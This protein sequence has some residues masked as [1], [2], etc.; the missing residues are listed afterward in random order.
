MNVT[1]HSDDGDVP[2]DIKA[3][4]EGVIDRSRIL[5]LCLGISLNGRRYFLSA[6][7]SLADSRESIPID[8]RFKL[9]C[10]SKVLGAAVVLELCDEGILDLR[11]P[12][13]QYLPELAGHVKGDKI[14]VAHLVS[15]T[16]GY[17][18]INSTAQGTYSSTREA[19]Y[20]QVRKAD[21]LFEPGQVFSYQNSAAA[22]LGEIVV[23]R[24]GVSLLELLR[25]NI[26]DGEDRL[27]RAHESEPR[28]ENHAIG[29]VWSRPDGRFVKCE[30][31]IEIDDL[32]QPA[33]CSQLAVSVRDLLL[34]AEELLGSKCVG[35]NGRKRF[36]RSTISKLHEPAVF[37]P[38]GSEGAAS[39]HVPVAYGYG[40]GR[41]ARGVLGHDSTMPGES[42]GFRVAPGAC[43]AIV[44]SLNSDRGAPRQQIFEAV[45]DALS[46]PNIP[47]SAVPLNISLDE[48]EGTYVGREGLMVDA[49]RRGP[50][51]LLSMSYDSKGLVKMLGVIDGT[52]FYRPKAS[53][54]VMTDLR[55][56]ICYSFFRE[57]QDGV[58]CL[59]MG[60]TAL[61]NTKGSL[62]K[63]K[64]N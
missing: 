7:Q 42:T 28:E 22:L 64:V 6:G 63:A 52:G 39:G 53:A 50:E 24:T 21:Q 17:M 19:L 61:K 15:H 14:T 25:E 38:R 49:R 26:A 43:C 40:L 55:E 45:F 8:T 9:G 2:T 5:G 23:R 3:A 11:A 10:L 48:L 4:V 37:I 33:M 34:K 29:H 54:G 57:P 36:S 31:A 12:I 60:V 41:Y 1:W 46:I 56:R 47:E 30:R 32:W 20:E 62:V 59:M 27:S 18:A 13:G 51:F 44:V 16:P 35:Q 58:P